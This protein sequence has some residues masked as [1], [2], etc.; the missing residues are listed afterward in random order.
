[1]KVHSLDVQ[2]TSITYFV[3]V[4]VIAV[5]HHP[6]TLNTL[7]LEQSHR[8]IGSEDPQAL[9]KILKLL[10]MDDLNT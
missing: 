8:C 6:H 9:S 5:E 2:P 10:K 1:M 3:K 7:P 4:S